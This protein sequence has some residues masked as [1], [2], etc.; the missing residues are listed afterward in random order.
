MSAPEVSDWALNADRLSITIDGDQ[1]VLV[2]SDDYDDYTSEGWHG[3]TDYYN[4]GNL[5]LRALREGELTWLRETATPEILRT[6]RN[7]IREVGKQ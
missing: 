4:D 6:I 5:Y 7:T 3:V 2:L 1:Y